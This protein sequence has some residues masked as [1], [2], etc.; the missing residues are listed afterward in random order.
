VATG[1]LNG[2][3]VLD[4]IIGNQGQNIIYLNDGHGAFTQTIFFGGAEETVDLAIADLNGDGK[5]DV[6]AYNVGTPAFIYI[7]DGVGNLSQQ[8]SFAPASAAGDQLAVGD[9]DG[10]GDY[11]LIATRQQ[12][13]SSFYRNNGQGSFVESSTLPAGFSPRLIDEGRDGDLD[14]FMLRSD[15]SQSTRSSLYRHRNNGSGTFSSAKITLPGGKAFNQ[16]FAVAD[17]D[18]DGDLDFIVSSYDKGCSGSGCEDLRLLLD[19]GLFGFSSIRLDTAAASKLSL[20]DLDNDG[21]LDVVTAALTANTQ[22]ADDRQSRVYLNNGTG[23][24]L[25]SASFAPVNVGSAQVAARELAVADFDN[26]GLL[27]I[28]LGSAEENTIYRNQPSQFFSSCTSSLLLLDP[29]LMADLNNDTYPDLILQSGLILYND[30]RGNFQ[31]SISLSLLLDLDSRLTTADLNGD[32]RL[33]LISTHQSRASTIY[34]QL[35]NG[36]FALTATLDNQSY[37]VTTVATGDINNDG[38]LDLILGRGSSAFASSANPGQ[39]L[40]YLNDGA[41]NFG[42]GQPFS[43]LVDDTQQIALG[44]L[45]ADGDLDIVVANSL[46]AAGSAQ[47]QQN[48]LYINDGAG[49]FGDPQPL[50]A[51]TDRTAAIAI[52]DLNGDG[53]LDIVLGNRGQLNAVHY[54]DGSGGFGQ[55]LLIGQLPDETTKLLLVDL[56]HDGDLDLIA[57]NEKQSDAF[58]TNNG[59][60][61]LTAVPTFSEP[62]PSARAYTIAAGD[63]DRDGDIDLVTDLQPISLLPNL[64]DCILMGKRVEPLSAPDRLPQIVAAQPG[65]TVGAGP[66]ASS[67]SFAQATIPF[68]FTLF[69]PEAKPVDIQAFY[70]LNG[71]GQWF[72]A[73]PSATTTTKNLATRTGN[74]AATHTFTWDVYASNFLGHS[75]NVVLRIEARPSH[76]PTANGQ[77]GPFTHPRAV[78]ELYPLRVRGTQV[79]VVNTAGE[80]VAGAFL[81][82]LPAGGTIRADTFPLRNGIPVRTNALGYIESRGQL[83]LGDQLIA[84]QPISATHAFTL[85]H[86]SA[87]PTVT[88]VEPFVV[89]AAGV[90]T[91]TVSADNPLTLFNL[92]VALEWDARNDGTF[93]TDLQYAIENAS[94]IL[95]DVSDGQVALGDVNVT[96][97]KDGWADAHV[98]IYANNSVHPRASMGG[99]VLTPTNDIGINGIIDNAYWPGQIHMGP[100]WDPFGQNEAELRQDWWLAFA[101]ELSHYLLFLPDNYLGIEQGLL[102]NIDCQ[103]SFMTN[104]YEDTY[105]E[106]LTRDR[107]NQQ[108]ACWRSSIAA[109]TTGRADWETVQRFLPWLQ[110]PPTADS[111]NPGPLRLPLQVTRVQIAA[112]RIPSA[113]PVLPARNFDLRNGDG[114]EITRLNQADA[115]LLKSRNTP[116]LDDDQIIA[117]GSTGAGSDRIKVRGAEV[118]D[119]LCVIQANHQLSQ[120]GCE[121]LTEASTSIRFHQTPGWQPEITVRPVSSTTLSITVTQAISP[122]MELRVQVLPIYPDL[123]Q[124][125]NGISPWAAL[126]PTGGTTPHEFHQ[127]I[128]LPTPL[129]EGFVRVWIANQ[130]PAREAMTSFYLSAGW[131]PNTRPTAHANRAVWGPNTRP[132][133][134]A[135]Q[136]AWGAN[137]RSMSA[138]IASSDGRVTIFN[139]DD[140]LGDTGASALQSLTTLPELPL[141]VTQ[142]GNGYRFIGTKDFAST[143]AFHYLEREVP[144]GYEHTLTVYYLA[145]ASAAGEARSWQRLPTFLDQD[146]NLA[147]AAMLSSEGGGIYAL[148]STVEMPMLNPTWNFFSYPIP[149]ER[150]VAPALASLAGAYT[151]IYE[152]E[153]NANVP[154]RLYDPAVAVE[155]PTFASFVNDLTALR[156]GHV[157]W[158]HATEEVTPYLGINSADGTD[159]AVAAGMGSFLPPAT[160]YGPITANGGLA[161]SEGMAINAVVDNMICGS[162]EITQR[163]GE[164]VYKLQV[165][166]SSGNT[167]GVQGSTVYFIVA[168]KAVAEQPEWDNRAAHYQPLTVTTTTSDLPNVGTSDSGT[169]IGNPDEGNP[170]QGNPDVGSPDEG[171]PGEGNPDGNDSA[172]TFPD[173]S[174]DD[175]QLFLPI[176]LR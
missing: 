149:G 82:K 18:N 66:Y 8:Q 148:M 72:P 111:V 174:D 25:Q 75:N 4:L 120:V 84:L 166:A 24:L 76:L 162:G 3:G 2:D 29:R 90:Q 102:R 89:Q 103:G 105:R 51:G 48:Y 153:M 55:S 139:L 176:L 127:T 80:P 168:G 92:D 113:M 152:Y 70:S 161:L 118:G 171:N 142:V 35:A 26:D 21:D 83:S 20:V 50:G 64:T 109:Q 46:E 52:G 106:F 63:I 74:G 88:G 71:G 11:D 158:L 16:H 170:D 30:R 159:N 49:N 99:I 32:G 108:E 67:Q 56:D 172:G 160:F 145:D 68:S 154:W 144:K 137:S 100:L 37:P 124:G 27:D 57:A 33:D 41:A 93:L 44:D 128:T 121:T 34:T 19:R 165:S 62:N 125:T 61:Q 7:N 10:D 45:D 28:L 156:F 130:L 146:E 136:R 123:T 81:Y 47:G 126:Q 78:A 143:I 134:H 164:W 17:L 129:F 91:L 79:R 104:T 157:Y 112:P 40:L 23:G 151:A 117:L 77:P 110:V 131:G 43:T 12:G 73:L 138:P 36:Q 141:W 133:A 60:G 135:N 116:Q 155:H 53:Q 169:P 150:A 65:Q 96:Q 58:F 31:L 115:Y 140:I 87:T 1:D 22:Q 69:D 59:G 101:H 175:F 114:G 167:C 5:L 147:A 38:H 9:L 42:A 163:M 13:N 97:A 85:Y 132:T 119:R 39:N 15:N 14:L 86:S 6:I 95:F 54:N 98:V 94:D 122:G 173:K 107:W